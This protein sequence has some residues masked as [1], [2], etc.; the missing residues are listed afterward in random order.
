MTYF[1]SYTK[2]FFPSNLSFFF[3]DIRKLTPFHDWYDCYQYV[4]MG[5]QI[6][7]DDFKDEALTGKF[8]LP[9]I[10]RV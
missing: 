2:K 3:H 5:S 9:G 4:N 10:H 6:F 7:T 8:S 1:S